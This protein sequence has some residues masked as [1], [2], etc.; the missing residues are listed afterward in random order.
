MDYENVSIIW[1]E[2]DEITKQTAFSE[3]QNRFYSVS[4]KYNKFPCLQNT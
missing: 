2:K 4:W 1:I 3:K